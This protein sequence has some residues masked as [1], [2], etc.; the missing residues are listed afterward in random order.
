MGGVSMTTSTRKVIVCDYCGQEEI[1]NDGI[2]GILF[3]GMVVRGMGGAVAPRRNLFICVEC[4]DKG[5][6]FTKLLIRLAEADEYTRMHEGG[7]A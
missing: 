4:I 6:S 7:K 1:D 3:R 5:V 2:D